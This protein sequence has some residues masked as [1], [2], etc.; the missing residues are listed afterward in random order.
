MIALSYW[1]VF[2]GL[3]ALSLSMKRHFRQCY[4]QRKMPSLKTL[5][6]FRIIGFTCLLLSISFFIAENGWGIGLVLWFGLLTIVVFLQSLLFTY[7]PQW[8]MS[9]GLISLLGTV[10]VAS[11]SL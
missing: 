9:I 3:V 8:I 4:P 5:F 1:L 2:V 10:S 7:K 11:L 6:V